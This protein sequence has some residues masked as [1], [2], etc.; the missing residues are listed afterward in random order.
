MANIS[1]VVE[2]SPQRDDWIIRV[3]VLKKWTEMIDGGGEILRFQLVDEHDGKI[4]A[5]VS[6]EDGLYDHFDL[7]V[8][9]G[10]WKLISGFVVQLTPPEELFSEN[11]HTIVFTENTDSACRNWYSSRGL[12]EFQGLHRHKELRVQLSSSSC[13]VTMECKAYGVLAVQIH[14]KWWRHGSTETFITM[15]DWMVYLEQRTGE[16]KIKDAGGISRFQFNA[17]YQ[18]V[19]DFSAEYFND[20]DGSVEE[21]VVLSP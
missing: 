2:L 17:N 15:S 12:Y 5:K 18:D 8:H 21:V 16:L 11:Q 9:E 7:N 14:D 20:S 13:G 6:S 4:P 1:R 10:H 19:Y 3:K